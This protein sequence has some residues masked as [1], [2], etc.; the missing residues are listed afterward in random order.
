[1]WFRIELNKD[2][3]VLKAEH[4]EARLPGAGRFVVYVDAET[5][6]LAMAS[7]VGRYQ[8]YLEKQRADM[9]ARREVR[10]AQGRC[11]D[12]GKPGTTGYLCAG[13]AERQNALRRRGR[14]GFGSVEPRP[15]GVHSQRE[16][17]LAE[18]LE[19]AVALR[20]GVAFLSWLRNELEAARSIH[21]K[22]AAAE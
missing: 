11:R 16:I 10:K 22:A 17:I 21:G 4:V 12:C 2:G 7:A 13:C 8:R 18:V 6:E 14:T 1:M 5:K 15:R 9:R 20:A 3:S 19:Q